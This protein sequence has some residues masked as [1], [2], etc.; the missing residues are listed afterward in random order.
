MGRLPIFPIIA[1]PLA[2]EAFLVAVLDPELRFLQVNGLSSRTQR[3]LN[4]D[5]QEFSVRSADA[6]IRELP[7]LKPQPTRG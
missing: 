5:A 7:P 4:G 1:P 2:F 3:S 6:P